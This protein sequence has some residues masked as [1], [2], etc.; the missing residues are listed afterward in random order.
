MTKKLACFVAGLLALPL[1]MFAQDL[2]LLGVCANL[3]K[4]SVVKKYNYAFLQPT[5]GDALQP[6][7]QTAFSIR[8]IK[9]KNQAQGYWQSMFLFPVPLKQP[10]PGLTSKKLLLMLPQFS[11][12]HKAR[13]FP[14]SFLAA[15][16]PG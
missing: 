9:L 16:L 8:E 11:K 15:V 13:V 2:P 6:Y 4:A 3:D 5:V 12:E 14:S 7:R 10:G 1:F